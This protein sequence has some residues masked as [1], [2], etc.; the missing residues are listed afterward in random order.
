MPSTGL[1]AEQRQVDPPNTLVNAHSSQ[2]RRRL[3][4]G[5]LD[6]ESHKPDIQKLYL[7]EKRELE[8]V[9]KIMKTQHSF[10]ASPKLYK[11]RFKIWGW[12]KNLPSGHAYFMAEKARKR[13]LEEGKSTVF[14]FGGQKWSEDRVLGSAERAKRARTTLMEID[15]MDTPSEVGYETPQS[16]VS[17]AT[18][19]NSGSAEASRIATRNMASPRLVWNGHTR[20]SLLNMKSEALRLIQRGEWDDA[21]ALLLEVRV[22]LAHIVGAISADSNQVGYALAE[23]YA[24]SDRSTKVDELIEGMTRRHIEALGYKDKKTQQHVLHC[25]ELL[26]GWNRPSDAIAFLSKCYELLNESEKQDDELCIQRRSRGNRRSKSVGFQS[27]GPPKQSPMTVA[28]SINTGSDPKQID[29]AIDIAKSHNEALDES[30]EALL[31]RTTQ[32]CERHPQRFPIQTLKARS[33]LLKFY[34]KRGTAARNKAAFK[35]S[36]LVFDTI[37]TTYLC[38]EDKYETFEVME[39][40]LQLGADVHK[41]GFPL[42]ASTMFHQVSNIATGTFNYDDERTVWIN[43][44]IGLVYQK[45]SSWNEAKLWFETAFAAV[46]SSDSWSDKDGIVRSLQNAMDKKPSLMYLTRGDLSKLS[47]ASR[48]LLYG[49]GD[50]ISSRI[51]IGGL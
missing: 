4:Y 7:E 36:K 19:S 17:N 9:I 38:L 25:V 31:L 23:L 37:F 6:W 39:A 14:T 42:I 12:Q 43:I 48:E 44:T 3:K 15:N 29:Y 47:S 16:E 21:E 51:R 30:A 26:N 41:G 24:E 34:L 1:A 2:P 40:A 11:D 8:E 32:I 10:E 27:K 46:L 18:D 50:Y 35:N 28:Q 45:Y 22:G 13:R 20:A 33:E 5:H 49:L